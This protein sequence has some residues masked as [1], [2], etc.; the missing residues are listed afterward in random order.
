M[1]TRR[2]APL[3]EDASG[4]RP[5]HPLPGRDVLSCADAA[6]VDWLNTSTQTVRTLVQDD[7]LDGYWQR[8]GQVYHFWVYRD[9]AEAFIDEHG[10]FPQARHRSRRRPRTD[11]AIDAAHGPSAS[12]DP[13][14][15]MRVM[16]LREVVRCQNEVI[17]KL[18]AA[19]AEQEI[20]ADYRRRAESADAK[21]AQLLR[22]ANETYQRLVSI[23]GIPN[24]ISG[25]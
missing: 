14:W 17:T 11:A 12:H 1:S 19:A 2:R 15:Q 3:P 25:V 18:H 8:V 22:E 4:S 24:D 20:A 16:E 13:G 5:G 6:A 10:P 21:A 23:Q 7:E 9:A